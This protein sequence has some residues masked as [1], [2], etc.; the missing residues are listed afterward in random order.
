[1]VLITGGGGG[2]G[3]HLALNFAR[4]NS[5]V[6]LWDI[7]RDGKYKNYYREYPRFFVTQLF[8]LRLKKMK[9]LNN[10][11]RSVVVFLIYDL[12]LVSIIS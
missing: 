1:M 7:N 6:V 10:L 5:K 9:L 8:H 4:M 2:V 11:F 12:L 3:K